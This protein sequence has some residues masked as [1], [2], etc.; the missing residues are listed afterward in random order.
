M[1]AARSEGDATAYGRADTRFH[2]AFFDGCG[3]S[4]LED[5]YGLASGRIAAL[6]THLTVKSPERRDV[7]FGEHEKIVSLFARNDL[8]GLAACLTEHIDRTRIVY[9]AVMEA[10]ILDESKTAPL[11]RS[12]RAARAQGAR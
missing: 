9:I 12:R 4:Y 2:Q 11:Q 1:V 8:G 6:R 3:N 7:S 5:A 10:G